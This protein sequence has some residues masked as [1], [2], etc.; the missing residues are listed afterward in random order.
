MVK[1]GHSASAAQGFTG[2]DPGHGPSTTHQ[3]M[4]RRR[5]TWQ[6]QKDLQ[7]EYTTMAWGTFGGEEEEERRIGKRC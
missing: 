6:S 1:F 2:S 7:L 5:P 4:L 3:A